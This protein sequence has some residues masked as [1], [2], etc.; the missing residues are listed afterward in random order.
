M[1]AKLKREYPVNNGSQY[2]IMNIERAGFW[3]SRCLCEI[4]K[5]KLIL[6]NRDAENLVIVCKICDD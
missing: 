1:K 5:R 3:K 6:E 4:N 2:G